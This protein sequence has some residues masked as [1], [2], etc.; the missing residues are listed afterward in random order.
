MRWGNKEKKWKKWTEME[1]QGRRGYRGKEQ[2]GQR[3]DMGTQQF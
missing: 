1:I 2:E 3:K